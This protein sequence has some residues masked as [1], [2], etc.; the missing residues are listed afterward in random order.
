MQRR[1]GA[2]RSRSD[3]KPAPVSDDADRDGTSSSSESSLNARNILGYATGDRRDP[4]TGQPAATRATATVAR[5]VHLARADANDPSTAA[6]VGQ[7]ARP[8]SDAGRRPSSTTAS[9]SQGRA[10]VCF[11]AITTAGSPGT[12]KQPP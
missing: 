6:K 9:V 10:C 11:G 1:V 7:V 3:N 4:D 2:P 8:P 12:R 5:A